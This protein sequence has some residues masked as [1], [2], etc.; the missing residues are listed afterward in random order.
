MPPRLLA[1][2]QACSLSRTLTHDVMS[3]QSLPHLSRR[4]RGGGRGRGMG[5]GGYSRGG[6]SDAD[7]RGAAGGF[8]G[9]GSMQPSMFGHPGM[10]GMAAGMMP[11]VGGL[12]TH[13]QVRAHVCMFCGCV[14]FW[15]HAAQHVWSF[16]HGSRH[17]TA[18]GECRHSYARICVHE[19]VAV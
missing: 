1:S 15:W 2:S 18:C 11:Q 19:L 9:Y 17:D 8:G 4:G 16:R 7:D 13:E 3:P 6:S 10:P 12:G 14:G 5:R